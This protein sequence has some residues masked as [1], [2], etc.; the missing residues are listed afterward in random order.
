MKQLTK[1]IKEPIHSVEE[2]NQGFVI[3]GEIL[4]NKFECEHCGS[5]FNENIKVCENCGR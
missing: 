3:V 4:I 5:I 1:K 2:L